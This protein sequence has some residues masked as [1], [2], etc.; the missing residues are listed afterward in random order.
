MRMPALL[1]RPRRSDS[2]SNAE[3]D[4]GVKGGVTVEVT[5]PAPPLKELRRDDNGKA[6]L[7]SGKQ[8]IQISSLLFPM[9][10]LRETPLSQDFHLKAV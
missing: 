1:D 9:V 6:L 3:W 5:S 2:H 8:K 10:H 4:A 7:A